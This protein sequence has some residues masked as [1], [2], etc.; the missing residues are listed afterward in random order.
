M[1]K[2]IRD[3]WVAALRSGEYLQTQGFL[4]RSNWY[5]VPTA[6]THSYCCLGVL[7]DLVVNDENLPEAN[8]VKNGDGI[9]GILATSEVSRD[10]KLAIARN[11]NGSVIDSSAASFTTN[12][13]VA[14]EAAFNGDLEDSYKCGSIPYN[15]A[16]NIDMWDG[17]HAKRFGEHGNISLQDKLMEMNDD[18]KTFGEIADWIEINVEVD[19]V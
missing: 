10:A 16:I 14:I 1:D 13:H 7:C 6:E 15:I 19:D 17:P 9:Y 2:L 12:D 4:H 11:G 3:K 5:E 8:W 18:G